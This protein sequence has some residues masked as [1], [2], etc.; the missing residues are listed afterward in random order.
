MHCSVLSTEHTVLRY[1]AA[2]ELLRLGRSSELPSQSIVTQLTL[3]L[4]SSPSLGLSEGNRG[5]LAS[6][7]K[8]RL[9]D[10]WKLRVQVVGRL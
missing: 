7:I 8:C 6:L 10:R 4:K 1:A 5:P 3:N 9:S 2:L